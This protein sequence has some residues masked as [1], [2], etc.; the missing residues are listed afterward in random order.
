[1][2]DPDALLAALAAERGIFHSEADFQHALA[3]RIR[4][5]HPDAVIRLET[6]P[7]RGTHLDVLE[8]ERGHRTALELKYLADRFTGVVGGEHFDLP[9]Q[10]AHDI[11]RSDVCRDVWRLET[12][13]TDGLCGLGHRHRA[14]QRRRLLAT[15]HEGEPD[16]RDVPGSPGTHD[17]RCARVGR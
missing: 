11:S 17:R 3:W 2:I 7:E 13:I 14:L 8:N 12:M 6:R 9:R 10:G 1:M 5:D 16:R 4:I 15:R